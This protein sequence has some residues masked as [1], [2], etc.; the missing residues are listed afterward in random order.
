MSTE[1]EVRE[2][3]KKRK[4]EN[5]TTKPKGVCI[6]VHSFLPNSI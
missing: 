4:E 3:K 1:H 5:S 2:K 6:S